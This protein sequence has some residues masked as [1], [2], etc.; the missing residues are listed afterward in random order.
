MTANGRTTWSWDAVDQ[1]ASY[2]TTASVGDFEVR[3]VTYSPSGVPIHDFV[4]TKLTTNQRNTT[5]ASLALQPRMIDF[6]ETTFGP[7]PFVSFG[8]IVDNDSVGYALETQTRPVYSGSA[9]PGHGRARAR[10]PVARQRR[11]PR[12]LEV[13]LAQRGLGDLRDVAVERGGRHPHG[14]G[15]LRHVV[16]PSAHAGVLGAA[17]R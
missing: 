4:D 7:Y 1:Q 13:H 5:N 10:A 14:P 11:Q 17:D 8:S 12:R 2:L 9:E 15:R 6:F 16:R 3:P